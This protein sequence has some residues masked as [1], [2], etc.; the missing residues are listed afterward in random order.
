MNVQNEQACVRERVCVCVCVWLPTRGPQCQSEC[1]PSR[2]FR[3]SIPSAKSYSCL[4]VHADVPARATQTWCT[5]NIPHNYLFWCW[6]IAEG[7]IPVLMSHSHWLMASGT[8]GW[9]Y[10]VLDLCHS[11]HWRVFLCPAGYFGPL[12][13]KWRLCHITNSLQLSGSPSI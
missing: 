6:P 11:Q 10:F 12:R 4:R 13:C 5:T 3:T 9:C 8:W 2:C 7:K 1:H